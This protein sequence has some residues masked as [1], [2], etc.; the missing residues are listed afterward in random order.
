MYIVVRRGRC[1]K[2]KIVDRYCRHRSIAFGTKGGP[3]G[4]D[5]G[6]RGEVNG[7]ETDRDLCSA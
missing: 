3:E 6:G 5:V 7:Y 4:D 1:E 2:G